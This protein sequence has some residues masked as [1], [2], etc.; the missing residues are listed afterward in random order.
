MGFMEWIALLRGVLA[1]PK[2]V[3]NLIKLLQK[4]PSEKKTEISK[5]LEDEAKK[6]E[7]T[8]RPTW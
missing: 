7:E 6:L 3:A 2:E 8:G 1:F 4:S 5:E